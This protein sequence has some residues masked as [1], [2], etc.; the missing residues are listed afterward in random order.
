MA[1]LLDTHL[2]YWI[3]LGSSR[4]RPEH[5]LAVA[6]QREPVFVSAVT[7]WEIATKVKLGKWPEAAPLLP[8]IVEK[9]RAAGLTVQPLTLEQSVCAGGFDVPHK[10]PFDRL[11]AAQALDLDLT[12]VT[13]DPAFALFGCKLL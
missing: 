8:D 3:V 10:D 1:L 13:V 7:G 5:R 9:V 4:L 2:F 12:L 6:A 11:I